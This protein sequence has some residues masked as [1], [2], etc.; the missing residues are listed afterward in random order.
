MVQADLRSRSCF[1]AFTLHR[2]D[3]DPDR[4]RRTFAD[5][6]HHYYWEYS[7]FVFQFV[8]ASFT[9]CKKDFQLG[10]RRV[11][12]CFDGCIFSF[13]DDLD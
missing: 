12:F 2:Y 13:C 3:L 6:L 11:Y 8:S 9:A 10:R 7:R 1:L 4:P 5:N